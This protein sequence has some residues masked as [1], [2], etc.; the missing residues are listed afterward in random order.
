M[1]EIGFRTLV[2]GFLLIG[3][4][5]FVAWGVIEGSLANIGLGLVATLLGGIGLW[6]EWKKQ[7]G[8][9]GQRENV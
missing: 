2:R 6:W 5:V 9:D 3:G 4:L 7:A 8:N 1:T